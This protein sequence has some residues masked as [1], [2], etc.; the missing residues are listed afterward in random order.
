MK[1][2]CKY[3]Y[4]PPKS[5]HLRHGTNKAVWELGSKWGLTYLRGPQKASWK[6]L[7]L[8]HTCRHGHERR[9]ALPV[10]ENEVNQGREKCLRSD[11]SNLALLLLC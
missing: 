2:I 5:K 10:A 1:E 4:N 7:V 3:Y 6:R 11:Q 8:S 9:N